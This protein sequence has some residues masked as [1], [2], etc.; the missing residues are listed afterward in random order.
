MTGKIVFGLRVR[1]QVDGNQ[2]IRIRG[3]EPR[4][5]ASIFLSLIMRGGNVS[6]YTISEMSTWFS[7][8]L[9]NAI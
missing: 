8:I 7:P 9:I 4:A 2:K 1:V 6:R 3:I 5:A